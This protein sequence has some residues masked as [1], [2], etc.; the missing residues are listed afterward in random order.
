MAFSTT[1][2]WRTT[3]KMDISTEIVRWIIKWILG[4][5]FIDP[6]GI[7]MA[8]TLDKKALKKTLQAHIN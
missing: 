7:W 8:V 4:K 2:S 6:E 1:S 3:C 5:Y